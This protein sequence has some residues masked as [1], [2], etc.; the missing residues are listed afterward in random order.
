VILP[1]LQYSF[2]FGELY[3]QVKIA[4]FNLEASGWHYLAQGLAYLRR[5]FTLWPMAL[6][7]ALCAD[8][9]VMHRH[10]WH[11]PPT[12]RTVLFIACAGLSGLALGSVLSALM[13]AH[14]PV[15]SN[16]P[17]QVPAHVVPEW[18]YLTHYSVLRAVT[19]KLG[20]HVVMLAALLA[21]AIWPWMRVDTLRTGSMRSLWALLCI[22]FAATWIGLA[23]LG[24][25]PSTSEVIYTTRALLTYYLAFLLIV[26]LMLHGL[27]RWKGV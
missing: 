4:Q 19:H 10:G 16:D 24:T 17:L 12:W 26:P 22:L 5:L 9:A 14:V 7:V 25:L 23:Y 20:G 15:A 27:A 18:F 11:W 6:L 1:L 2:S 3:Y 13:P 21:P 8:V